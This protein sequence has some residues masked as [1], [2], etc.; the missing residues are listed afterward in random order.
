MANESR[1]LYVGMT[2]NLIGR[3]QQHK[4]KVVDGFTKKYNLTKLVHYEETSDV[5]EALQREKQLKGWLRRRKVALIEES[6]P[7]VD[8]FKSGVLIPFR[9]ERSGFGTIIE[10]IGVESFASYLG[11]KDASLLRRSAW[12]GYVSSS[13]A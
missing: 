3:V 10:A 13:M 2:S 6:K 1:M 11:A 7:E 9:P 4:D 12:H 5:L 8:G